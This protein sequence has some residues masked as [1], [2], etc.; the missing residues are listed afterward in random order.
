[1]ICGIDPGLTG[2]ISFIHND[3]IIAERI[4]VLT[5]KKK[6]FLDLVKIINRLDLYKPERV[7]IEKQQAMPGQGVSSTFRT[8][9]NYGIYLGTFVSLG[10]G[11]TEVSP[12]KWKGDLGVSSNKDE[13]R[14]RATEL[15]PSAANNWLLKCEDGVA[16]AAMIAYWGCQQ[17]TLSKGYRQ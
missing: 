2:G 16:E 17:S 7:F 13:A 11:Y 3:E 5:I 4:P 9:F 12:R 10:I 8:G 6:K 15:M 1:M 14:Q